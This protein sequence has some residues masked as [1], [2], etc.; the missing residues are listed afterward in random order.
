MKKEKTI[1]QMVLDVYKKRQAA[2]DILLACDV[3]LDKLIK[4][5]IK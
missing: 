5:L 3:F 4:E 1:K 2:H